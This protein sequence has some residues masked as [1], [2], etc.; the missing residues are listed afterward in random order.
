MPKSTTPNIKELNYG[1]TTG[2]PPLFTAGE[3]NFSA[4]PTKLVLKHTSA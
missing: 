3:D 2:F 4:A 1:T